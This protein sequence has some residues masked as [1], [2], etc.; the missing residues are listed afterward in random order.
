[1]DYLAHDVGDEDA[2]FS[3]SYRK[4]NGFIPDQQEHLNLAQ[5]LDLNLTLQQESQEQRQRRREQQ[6]DHNNNN[7]WQANSQTMDQQQQF[8]N[9]VQTMFGV[10]QNNGGVGVGGS[11]GYGYDPFADT[12]NEFSHDVN[13]S[14]F[15][16]ALRVNLVVFVVLIGSYELFRK[17]FPTVYSP[18]GDG[19]VVKGR[20]KNKLGPTSSSSSLT[21]PSS[22]DSLANASAESPS[23]SLPSPMA[24]PAVNI[25]TK[26]PLG[27]I[28]GVVRASW[29]AVRST[30]GLDS[31]MF[32]RY[33]RLCFRITFTSALWGMIILWPIYAS[34][35]GGAAGW[36]F[37]S[38]ANITQGS[39]R[40]WAPTVFIWL[41]TLYV[42]FLMNQEY[43][44]YLECRVDF[45][46]R[47]DGM[48]TSQQHMY[49][50]IVERIPH[51]LRSDRAL[52]DYFHRLFPRKVYST[53]VVLNLP[54]LERESQKR[55]RVLRRLEKSMVSLEVRGRRPRHVVGRKRLR[56]CGIETS[57]IFSSFGGNHTGMDDDLSMNSG[58]LPRRGENVDSINYYSRE[59][60]IMNERIARMQHE[61]IELAQKGNDSMR[62]SQWIS[63][64]IDRV[65]SAAESTLGPSQDDGLITGFN[66]SSSRRK[67]LLLFI[68]DRMGIDFISGAINLVQQNIDEV[69]DS[70]VGATM[71]STGFITFNDLSTLACALKTPLYHKPD[72]LVVKMA[73]EHRDIIWE[74]AHVNLGWRRS[75]VLH[76]IVFM[77]STEPKNVLIFLS[78]SSVSF[79]STGGANGQ[80]T[81]CWD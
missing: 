70:V 6:Y 74:N 51:E 66:S 24:R 4:E 20:G 3:Q 11:L 40:L 36:Y 7:D 55:K 58:R 65:S 21:P 80:R 71:S 10:G 5:Q 39:Q 53:A 32:L 33:V 57:P 69:V 50:L 49:S 73:P 16:T 48:V 81:C 76:H 37:L 1:M 13:T 34:G 8:E 14:A 62:A 45:L 63:H 47:G 22:R 79:N 9:N 42:L 27:W 28:P 18:K 77:H 72:V 67:P 38:M 64:A 23:S 44:H 15:L 35:D 52:Y 61:K 25:N 41:Q 60:S 30:G 75:V 31:Y 46:A 54:D 12:N 19:A 56:C 43:E 17:W 26:V 78:Q 2:V 29:S 68:L 59:L